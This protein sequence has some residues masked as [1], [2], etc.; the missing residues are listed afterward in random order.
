MFIPQSIRLWVYPLDKYL[1][2]L[3]VKNSD[4]EKLPILS[5]DELD[6][7]IMIQRLPKSEKTLPKMEIDSEKTLHHIMVQQI[8]SGVSEDSEPLKLDKTSKKSAHHV[9]I[10]LPERSGDYFEEIT[11]NWTEQISKI[12][13]Q[14]FNP[15]L[16]VEREEIILPTTTNSTYVSLIVDKKKYEF[17]KSPTVKAIDEKEKECPN[18]KEEVEYR[19]LLESKHQYVY[20]IKRDCPYTFKFSFKIGIPKTIK[21]WAWLAFSAAITAILFS[22]VNFITSYS[23]YQDD[24]KLLAGIVSFIVALR[25]LV[26]HDYELMSV[27]NQV[28][29]ILITVAI[30]TVVA[31]MFIH[32][33]WSAFPTLFIIENF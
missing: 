17:V 31:I 30:G 19:K 28:F 12:E 3:E 5:Y 15:S 29:L 26:F 33:H 13:S 14:V 8:D 7:L 6:E 25:V 21:A 18:V 23:S 11:I 27:W 9:G 4:N 16:F 32:A 24:L 1:A 22:W 20:R 2:S 10:L